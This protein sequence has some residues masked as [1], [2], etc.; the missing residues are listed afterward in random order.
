MAHYPNSTLDEAKATALWSPN[1][2]SRPISAAIIGKSG[3]L[4]GGREVKT[5]VE[6]V[7]IHRSTKLSWLVQALSKQSTTPHNFI[8]R[9]DIYRPTLFFYSLQHSMLLASERRETLLFKTTMEKRFWIQGN[10]QANKRNTWHL[11]AN[12]RKCEYVITIWICLESG[13]RLTCRFPDL[14]HLVDALSPW[15]EYVIN[16]K[17]LRPISKNY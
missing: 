14:C 8:Y 12:D 3:N 6:T 11:Q 7:M 2:H 5:E 9:C 17:L 4:W 1:E 13:V 16:S 10:S 15:L